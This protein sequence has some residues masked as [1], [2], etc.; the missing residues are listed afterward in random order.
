MAYTY[1][2][3]DRVTQIV[4][5]DQT[6]AFAYDAGTY[7]KGHL[8]ELTDASGSTEWVYNATGRVSSKQHTIGS[9]PLTVGYGYNSAGQLTSMTTPSG[10]SIGYS[11]TNNRITG[12]TVNSSALLSDVLYMPFGPTRGW[13]WGNSTYTVREYDTDGQLTTLDSAGASTFTYHPDGTIASSSD[14]GIAAA[15]GITGTMTLNVSSASNRLTSTSGTS[16]RTYTYDAAGNV[17]GD[18]THTFTYNGAGRMV[19]STTGGVTTSYL[20][21]ALGQRVKKSTGGV[22]RYFAYDEA[23]HL[24]GEYDNSGGLIQETV[25]LDDVPVATLRP[26]GSGGVNVFYVHTD[27]LNTPRRISRPSNNTVLWQW[28]SDPFGVG[29]AS[30]DPDGDTAAFVYNLRF[31]GQ[32]YDSETGLNYNSN[33]YYDFSTGRYTQSDLIGLAGGIGTYV[34]AKSN[35]LTYIDPTG[36][37]PVA[38]ITKLLDWI[39]PK[40]LSRDECQRLREQ[41]YRK[42]QLLENELKVYD[43]VQDGLGGFPMAYGSRIT[44]PGGHYTEIRDL[45]RGLKRDLKTYN[46][47]C[48]CDN[49]DDGNTAISRNVDELANKTVTPPAY[50]FFVLPTP[51]VG[52]SPIVSP[53]LVPGFVIP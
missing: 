5:S 13:Q 24:L 20:Y 44:K 18:G 43:P 48:R 16:A 3:A 35:P 31:P 49:N 46:Q 30:E 4:Y 32:Y 7:G 22:A 41:I 34:Y 38:S 6:M 26:N 51:G 50:P 52:V 14:S 27:H 11:Y 1:D 45:Q 8:T 12:I 21:N 40:P 10:Q 39:D 9:Q 47:R 53:G 36:L 17:T 28:K 29:A 33:R 19:T 15:P 23:G 25:W 2:A 37:I 42:N